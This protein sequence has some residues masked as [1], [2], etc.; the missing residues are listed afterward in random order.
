MAG[1][2]RSYLNGHMKQ[3]CPVRNVAAS[4][5]AVARLVPLVGDGSLALAYPSAMACFAAVL[6]NC[7][8][9]ADA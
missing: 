4:R 3:G 1:I 9:F 2:E 6:I 8:R 5:S 7:G